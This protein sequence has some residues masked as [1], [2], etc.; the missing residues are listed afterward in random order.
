MVPRL[1]LSG[2]AQWQD[3]GLQKKPKNGRRILAFG[4][5]DNEIA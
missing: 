5:R 4:T 2:R 1:G 3:L